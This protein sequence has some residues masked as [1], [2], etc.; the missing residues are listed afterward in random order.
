MTAGVAGKANPA[1][2]I[3]VKEQKSTQ[4]NPMFQNPMLQKGPKQ[5]EP[6]PSPPALEGPRV[7]VEDVASPPVRESGSTYG[8]LF[9]SISPATELRRPSSSTELPTHAPVP[10]PDVA[11]SNMSYSA[12]PQ[13]SSYPETQEPT[14]LPEAASSI[15][16]PSEVASESSPS[17]PHQPET[18]LAAAGS[19]EA[20]AVE[21]FGDKPQIATSPSAG[22]TGASREE[23]VR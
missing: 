22:N 5:E 18:P 17:P 23:E 21:S 10:D 3:D 14:H 11:T 15:A 19:S 16:S 12:G 6:K 1:A 20:E 2:K 8:K 4:N 7:A 13:V 9:P